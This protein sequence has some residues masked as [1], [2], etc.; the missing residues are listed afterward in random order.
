LHWRASQLGIQLHCF[1]GRH[2]C[3]IRVKGIGVKGIGVKGIGVKGVR[4]KRIGVK[5]MHALEILPVE[6]PA[7][8]L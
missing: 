6:Y 3:E 2:T 5:S 1:N 4:I 8:L 7:P